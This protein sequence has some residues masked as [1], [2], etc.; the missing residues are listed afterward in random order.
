VILILT[1]LNKFEAQSDQ[2]LIERDIGRGVEQR[3]ASM[4]EIESPL[5]PELPICDAH[6]HLW[7]RPPSGYMLDVV[8]HWNQISEWSKSMRRPGAK[9]TV[10]N[11]WRVKRG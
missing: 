7:K 2:S 5:E 11:R 1:G 9:I 10:R 8:C 4:I 6:H 3:E